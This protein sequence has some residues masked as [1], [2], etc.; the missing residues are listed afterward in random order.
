MDK[1]VIVVENYFD[2]FNLILPEIKKTKL[3]TQKE[4]NKKYTSQIQTWP[5]KRSGDLY[6][7]SPILLAY[8]L[9]YFNKFNINVNDVKIFS[10]IHLRGQDQ[11]TKDW[12]HKDDCSYSMLVYLNNTNLN[13]GTYLYDESNNIIA[14]VKYVQNRAVLYNGSYNHMG[15]GHFGDSPEN[16]RLTLNFF[17][18]LI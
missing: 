8:A 14:D 18:H 7:E 10:Y 12:I 1:R 15:Y 11:Q 17:I 5:G 4:F 6:Q 9:S 13:S 16:G 3:Y 2:H